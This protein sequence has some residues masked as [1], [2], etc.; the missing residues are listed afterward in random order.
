MKV[1]KKPRGIQCVLVFQRLE[2]LRLRLSHA[3]SASKSGM[4]ENTLHTPELYIYCYDN[5]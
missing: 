1:H 4:D 2:F 3:A 5:I